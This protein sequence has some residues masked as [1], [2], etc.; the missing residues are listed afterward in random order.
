MTEVNGPT[1]T[2]ALK[3]DDIPWAT[4]GLSAPVLYAD[5]IRG[6]M[7]SADI[8]KFNLVQNLVNTQTNELVS[9]HVATVVLPTSQM[10][11]WGQWLIDTAKSRAVNGNQTEAAGGGE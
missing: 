5:T 1:V 7:V 3:Q 6:A 8:A 11:A 2:H 10:E 4:N 9:V